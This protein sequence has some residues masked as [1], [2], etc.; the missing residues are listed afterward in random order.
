[1]SAVLVYC[2]WTL[3]QDDDDDDDDDDY[4]LDALRHVKPVE[5]VMHQ[6]RQAAVKLPRTS[7]NTGCCI[8]HTFQFVRDDLWGPCENRERHYNSPLVTLQRRGRV[9]LQT[10]Q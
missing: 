10:P 7:Q 6:L 4:I 9:S 5:I 2:K 8:H 3:N 1:M